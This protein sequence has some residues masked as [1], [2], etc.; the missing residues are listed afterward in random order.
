MIESIRSIRNN[1]N[2]VLEN[3]EM[4]EYHQV[5]LRSIVDWCNEIEKH[6]IDDGK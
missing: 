5:L 4:S 6:Y 3:V 1:A 2:E